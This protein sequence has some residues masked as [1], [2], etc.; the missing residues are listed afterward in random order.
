M[1]VILGSLCFKF[2]YF[3]GHGFEV[4]REAGYEER[5]SAPGHSHSSHRHSQGHGHQNKTN[6]RDVRMEQVCVVI[7]LVM[8]YL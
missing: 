6:D 5:R 8:F 1:T 7:V 3:S 2:I 4:R